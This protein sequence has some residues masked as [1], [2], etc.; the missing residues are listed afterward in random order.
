MSCCCE[1]DVGFG[2]RRWAL[3]AAEGVCGV[4][5]AGIIGTISVSIPGEGYWHYHLWLS[6]SDTDPTITNNLPSS[7]IVEWQGVTDS[8]GTVSIDVENS[9]PSSSW[10]VWGYFN[11]LNVSDVL[12]VGV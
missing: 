11:K 12:T 2:V 4:S 6:D 5:V 3:T 7:K 1:T 10:Y 9:D 8:D